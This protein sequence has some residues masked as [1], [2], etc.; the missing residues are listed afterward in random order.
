M[1]D[2]NKLP[3]IAMWVFLL[4]LFIPPNPFAPAGSVAVIESPAPGLKR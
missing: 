1:S 4:K 3:K 2:E